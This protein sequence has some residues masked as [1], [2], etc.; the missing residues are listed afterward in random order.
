MGVRLFVGAV[1]AFLA[2]SGWAERIRLDAGWRFS[3]DPVGT[4][5]FA[6]DAVAAWL[7]AWTDSNGETSDLPPTFALARG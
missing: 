1:F 3:C 7:D 5:A 4:R 2:W 6:H